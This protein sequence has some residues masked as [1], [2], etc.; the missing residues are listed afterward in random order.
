MKVPLH[1]SLLLLAGLLA[2][3]AAL[4]FTMGDKTWMPPSAQPLDMQG[5]EVPTMGLESLLVPD[6]QVVSARPLFSQSRRPE[7]TPEPAPEGPAA[8]TALDQVVVLGLFGSGPARGGIF[9][10]QGK[11]V[12]LL[13]GERLGSW[14]LKRVEGSEVEFVG[15][16][17][18]SHVLRVKHLPQPAATPGAG[19]GGGAKQ[20][21]ARLPVPRRGDGDAPEESKASDAAP[22]IN[23]Q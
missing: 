1:V 5:F 18:R 17:G 6:L 11:V 16:D 20:L 3:G 19:A 4:H 15:D 13:S 14:M 2:G 7:E 8:P 12:R 9:R 21:P 22:G 23:V 10:D